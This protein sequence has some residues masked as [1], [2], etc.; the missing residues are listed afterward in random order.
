MKTQ[1]LKCSLSVA[2]L[3]LA[4]CSGGGGGGG[5]SASGDAAA[6][7]STI[8][9]PPTAAK[10]TSA[11]MDTISGSGAQTTTLLNNAVA[12]FD[13]S[14][15]MNQIPTGLARGGDSDC[16][17]AVTPIEQ[18]V[19]NDNDGFNKNLNV[20]FN[21]SEPSE[22]NP[23][24]TWSEVSSMVVTDADDTTANAN[25]SISGK[26]DT[27]YKNSSGTI[28]AKGYTAGNLKLDV[29]KATLTMN[30]KN[31]G[32]SNISSPAIENGY[33]AFWLTLA[34]TDPEVSAAGTVSGYVQIYKEGKGIVT[35][36]VS[37]SDY[38]FDEN[39]RCLN[40]GSV[41]LKYADGTTA[42][43]P[44]PKDI[45]FTKLVPSK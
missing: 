10:G 17:T 23:D 36:S 27:T 9:N 31:G 28:V 32:F 33:M 12:N 5:G 3:S 19:D 20:K 45:C 6:P 21:C 7:N 26:G 40:G 8:T 29:S 42:A 24:L 16:M 35:L 44:T 13:V 30:Y 1:I 34:V 25:G 38:V 43:G 39:T 15:F 11:E 18:W 41:T 2:L 37:S 14:T 22:D 4:A